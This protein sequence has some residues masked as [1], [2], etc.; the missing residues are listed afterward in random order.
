MNLA[1]NSRDAMPR[2]GRLVIR[3]VVE[4]I[5]PEDVER[6]PEAAPGLHICLSVM[7]TGCGIA[8]EH[9]P[10]I[11]EP[12]F[13]T[14]EVGKG[15]GLGLAT[16]YGIV[17]QHRG[18]ID[19]KTEVGHGA[20]FHIHL[21]ASASP[22]GDR[23]SGASKRSLPRGTE[24]ILL[25]EDDD[26]VRDVARLALERFGYSV[27]EASSGVAALNLWKEHKSK[28]QLMLTDM[29]M[30]EGMTGLD[31]S[32]K[33]KRLQQGALRQGSSVG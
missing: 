4:T 14:K 12:F 17:K 25:V 8:P 3:T 10:H 11:F 26:A 33:L 23:E 1:V 15:T 5:T 13:T 32:S 20:A 9:L 27:L 6:S 2:G 18:W 22:E 31:L 24:T 30:P 19:V 21:P 28:I 7:D 29:V 16:V